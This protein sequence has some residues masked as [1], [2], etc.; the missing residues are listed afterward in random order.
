M[1]Q[2]LLLLL[3]GG[4]LVP[5]DASWW[6][7]LLACPAHSTAPLLDIFCLHYIVI[8]CDKACVAGDLSPASLV[9]AFGPGR[10]EE[11]K[12]PIA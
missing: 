10:E 6:W 2:L 8:L 11:R 12:A 7:W 3:F 9:V 1:T 5:N 4:C